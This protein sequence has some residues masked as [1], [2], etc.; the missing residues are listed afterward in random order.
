M[1]IDIKPVS[2]S[3]AINLDL[4]GNVPVAIFSTE[5]FDT[6]TVDPTSALLACAEIRFKGKGYQANV[7]DVNGEGLMDLVA[8]IETTALDLSA[9]S[10]NAVL[11]GQAGGMTI[12]GSDF[13]TVVRE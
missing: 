8:H 11:E 3:N 13:V 7:E 4:G 9:T 2:L 1:A 10:E 12:R 5:A 6:T